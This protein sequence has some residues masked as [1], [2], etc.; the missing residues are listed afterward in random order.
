LFKQALVEVILKPGMAENAM[1][2][3]SSVSVDREDRKTGY[4]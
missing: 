3:N 1:E 2:V 4:T